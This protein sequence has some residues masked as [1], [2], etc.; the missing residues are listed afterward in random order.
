MTNEVSSVAELE[1]ILMLYLKLLRTG[2]TREESVKLV[3]LGAYGRPF[4]ER[5][6]ARAACLKNSS[7]RGSWGCVGVVL[8]EDAHASSCNRF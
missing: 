5:Y 8:P 2:R 1:C 6:V 7:C 4:E 3:S